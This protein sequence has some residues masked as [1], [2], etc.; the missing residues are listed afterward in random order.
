MNNVW[1]LLQGA[2]WG[3]LLTTFLIMFIGWLDVFVFKKPEFIAT[4]PVKAYSIISAWE[5]M[6]FLIGF[7]GGVLVSWYM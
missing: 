2:F 4:S 5:F 3:S 1:V 6:F 7:C